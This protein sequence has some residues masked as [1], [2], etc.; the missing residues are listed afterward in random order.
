MH[1]FDTTKNDKVI[2]HKQKN[3]IEKIKLLELGFPKQK[4]TPALPEKIG[5][6]GEYTRMVG[7]LRNS[8]EIIVSKINGTKNTW[9]S[10]KIS[11][12]DIDQT[13]ISRPSLWHL[14]FLLSYRCRRLLKCTTYFTFV[15]NY[16][17]R[18]KW[19]IRLTKS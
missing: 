10:G 19:I 4:I 2:V 17:Y 1:E 12:F 3:L 8:K 5:N 7:P 11:W 15:W 9:S 14:L 13:E 6:D 18:S 16:R